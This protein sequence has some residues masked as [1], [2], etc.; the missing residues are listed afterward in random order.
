MAMGILGAYICAD[1]T[2]ICPGGLERHQLVLQIVWKCM[3]YRIYLK[4]Y[5]EREYTASWLF[6]WFM[7]VPKYVLGLVEFVQ[8]LCHLVNIGRDEAL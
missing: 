6:V 8:L 1:E 7:L 5:R 4:G 2:L 3:E